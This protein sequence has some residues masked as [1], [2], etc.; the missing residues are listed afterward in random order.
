MFVKVRGTKVG[1]NGEGSFI[2]NTDNVRSIEVL[3]G[4]KIL[5]LVGDNYGITIR[6]E[7]FEKLNAF[8]APEDFTF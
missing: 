3:R 1:V 8:L 7:D 5:Y 2:V 6:D 4:T